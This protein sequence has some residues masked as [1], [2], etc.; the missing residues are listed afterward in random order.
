MEMRLRQLWAEVLGTPAET[1]GVHHSFFQAGGDS[2]AAMKLSALTRKEGLQLTVLDIFHHPT[3][4]DM[5]CTVTSRIALEADHGDLPLK[6]SS[7]ALDIPSG[8]L[9]QLADLALVNNWKI[10]EVS[11]ATDL[12]SLFVAGAMTMSRWQLNYYVLRGSASFDYDRLKTSC[13][14][15]VGMLPMLRTVFLFSGNRCFQAVLDSISVHVAL[16]QVDDD[17]DNYV[18]ALQR[19][20]MHVPPKCGQPFVAFAIVKHRQSEQH[21]L[22]IR[23]SHAQYDGLSL[24]TIW[25]YFQAAYED[26]SYLPAVPFSKYLS[27]ITQANDTAYSYWLKML[28]GASMTKVIPNSSQLISNPLKQCTSPSKR[29]L[30]RHNQIPGITTANILKA[31]WALVLCQLSGTSD[32]IFGNVVSGRNVPVVQVEDVVGPCLNIVPFRIQLQA[33]WKGMDLLEYIQHQQLRSVPFE[34]L[35]F[36]EIFKKCTVWPPS[37]R[38]TSAIL[39]Q[40][41]DTTDRLQLGQAM[42]EIYTPNERD[43]GLA[44]FT[45]ISVPEDD[46]VLVSLQYLEG[47]VSDRFAGRILSLLCSTVDFLLLSPEKKIPLSVFS[48]YSCLSRRLDPKLPTVA[49]KPID[50]VISDAEFVYSMIGEIWDSAFDGANHFTFPPSRNASFLE[51]GGDL[52]TAAQIAYNFQQKGYNVSVEEVIE[53]PTQDAQALLLLG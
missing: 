40:N 19:E 18:L 27:H 3:L 12:Q 7:S 34:T 47:L 43:A 39:H 44:D 11:P 30:L 1:I 13:I 42:Y 22:L 10:L 51:L 37:T 35:G 23:I 17:L 41:F 31:A 33:D 52:V 46:T 29:I 6:V 20:D 50:K 8:I 25:D 15:L 45:I 9:D 49:A 14:R 24:P 38:F 5:T 36:R 53:F 21:R 32:V 28:E 2:L 16:H 4:G 48:S 26:R